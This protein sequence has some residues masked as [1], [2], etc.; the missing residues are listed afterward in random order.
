MTELAVIKLLLNKD[1]YYKYINYINKLELEKEY[2]ILIN[3][4]SKYYE[5]FITHEYISIDELKS[6]FDIHYPNNKNSAEFILLFDKVRTLE[7]SD[8]LATKYVQTIIEKNFAA[9]MM[10]VIL[11]SLE[12]TDIGIM[13]KLKNLVQEC[14]SALSIN[15]DLGDEFVTDDLD[16]LLS[17]ADSRTGLHWRLNFLEQNVGPLSGGHLLHVF[18]RTDGG[19]T[20]L[21][22]SEVSNFASQLQDG[23]TGLWFNNE[24]KQETLK[25]RWMA[26]VLGRPL[27]SIIANKEA[28][29]QF[30]M[31]NRG[32][33][34]KFVS[35]GKISIYDIELYMK[36]LNPRF[37]VI[38]IADKITTRSHKDARVDEMLG[39]LYNKFHELAID[40]N[41]DIITAAQ[42]SDK[43]TGKKWLTE[44]MMANSKTAKP[45]ELDVAIGIGV[46]DKDDIRRYISLP[47]NKLQSNP[48]QSKGVVKFIRDIAR[49]EDL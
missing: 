14:E 48:E 19:K 41:A 37:V 27:Q 21:L 10:P 7:V 11:G 9:Q 3:I 18:A 12:G 28:A 15:E 32:H 47:K 20:S 31:K 6:Y 24:G 1:N 17:A 5:E 30:F 43:A 16:E 39:Q 44:D 38:D 2:K 4:I 46:P 40:Y 35:R 26:A 49:F 25:L 42:A 13:P 22:H 36:M 45:G 8:S 33:Q 29:Q 34:V 23:E